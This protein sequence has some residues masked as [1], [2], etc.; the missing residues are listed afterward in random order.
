MKPQGTTC[1][2]ETKKKEKKKKAHECDIIVPL[3][4][5]IARERAKQ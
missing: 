5:N 1:C 4:F 3:N 2:G